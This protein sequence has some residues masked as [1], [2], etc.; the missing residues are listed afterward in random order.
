MSGYGQEQFD[1]LAHAYPVLDVSARFKQVPEDFVVDE[2]LPFELTGQGE[3]AWLHVR[4]RDNNTDWVA[5]K[6]AEFAGVKKNAVGYAGLKDRFAVTTQWF[7]VYLP[8]RDDVD[9]NALQIEGV[10]ILRTT[11]HRKKLQRGALKQNRFEIRLRDIRFD[12]DDDFTQLVARCDRIRQTG[13]PNYFGQ[14][15]FGRDFQNLS[16]AESLFSRQ[17]KRISKHK[18]GLLL[19]AAR[20]WIFNSILSERVDKDTWHSAIKGD[21][22][23]LDGRSACFRDDGSED[24]GQ[25]IDRGEIHPSGVLWGDGETMAAQDCRAIEAEVVD[26]FPLFRQ[27]LIDARVEQQRRPLRLM[28]KD[29]DCQQVDTD[30]LLRFSLQAGAY[31]TTVLRELIQLRK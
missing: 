15:R 14:Q 31:A 23:M 19:S 5:T 29:L 3:H 2:Q 12:S 7:S 28:V 1:Q 17:R 22:F 25:R 18:R 30:W 11:R 24:I 4:K 6:I 21:V 26:R 10:E 16:E 20:S 9:W 8:G 13:V 27:G